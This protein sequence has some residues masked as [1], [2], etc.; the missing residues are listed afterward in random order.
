MII[1]NFKL[2]KK[3]LLK[4]CLVIMAIIC[5]SLITVSIYNIFFT[6]P[7]SM[8]L[9]DDSI[10]SNEPAEIISSNYTNILKQVHNN[11]DTYVGQKIKFTGYVYKLDTFKSNQ[12]VLARDM[13]IGDKKSLVVGFLCELEKEETLE[14]STW[15]NVTGSI[16][17]GVYNDEEIPIIKVTKIEKTSMPVNPNVPMPDD[18]YVPTALIY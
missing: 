6:T 7:S 18:E 2:N 17:K 3:L 13:D 12:F 9:I 8:N 14:E 1:Y 4:T 5:F 10:P 15:V 16:E 11:L